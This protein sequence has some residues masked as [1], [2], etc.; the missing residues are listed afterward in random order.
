MRMQRAEWRARNP[1]RVKPMTRRDLQKLMARQLRKAV[2]AE[3]FPD[4][5]DMPP[6][7][8]WRVYI[9]GYDE[10]VTSANTKSD[11]RAKIK[12]VLGVVP[13]GT[14]IEKTG[15]SPRR[16][17]IKQ[18]VHDAY[19]ARSNGATEGS[20]LEQPTEAAGDAEPACA[21][22]SPEPGLSDA[23]VSAG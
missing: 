11:V 18:R 16:D 19:L 14:S 17:Y 5:A 23:G 6:I 1:Q 8:E 4:R 21:T 10:M 2:L 22:A 13:P 12:R 3:I 20:G 7:F 15:E 9:P